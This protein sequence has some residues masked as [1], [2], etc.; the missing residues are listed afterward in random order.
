MILMDVI[1][2]ATENIPFIDNSSV[3]TV[4]IVIQVFGI[5]GL[6]WK[7]AQLNTELQV[8]LHRLEYDANNLGE[9]LRECLIL[10]EKL[11]NSIEE[12]KK[13]LNE[14]INVTNSSQFADLD[15]YSW[16]DRE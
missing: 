2:A 1:A 5:V 14:L 15:K 9:K 6:T 13:K 10:I 16:R 11:S 3:L 7:I 8:R 4:G 12:Q